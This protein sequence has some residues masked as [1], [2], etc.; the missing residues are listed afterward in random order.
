MGSGYAVPLR[1]ATPMQYVA[2]AL[3]RVPHLFLDIYIYIYI[4]TVKLVILAAIIFN[5]LDK[6]EGGGR[7]MCLTD[8]LFNDI[9][10][11]TCELI[12]NY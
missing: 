7:E 8:F 3:R 9:L 11:C 10:T 6:T 12:T 1:S 5:I 2:L 4:Y